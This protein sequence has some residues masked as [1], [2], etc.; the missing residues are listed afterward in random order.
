[1]VTIYY[2]WIKIVGVIVSRAVIGSLYLSGIAINSMLG[3]AQPS[4]H[5][6]QK[7]P[8]GEI[9]TVKRVEWGNFHSEKG[10][11]GIFPVRSAT[12]KG[13]SFWNA[14]LQYGQN[15]GSEIAQWGYFIGIGFTSGRG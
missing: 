11:M 5:R 9:S 14:H 15:L 1:M 2:E 4:P 13:V 12:N 6:M 10:R 3:R 7:G 8:N